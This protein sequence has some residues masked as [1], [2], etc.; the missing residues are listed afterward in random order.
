LKHLLLLGGGHSH[1][2]VIRRFGDRPRLEAAMTLVSPDRH[3]PYSGMLPGY[4]A[5]HYGYHDCHIDLE[6]LC[7]AAG[8]VFRRAVASQIHPEARRVVCSDGTVVS[9]D[10]V[11][12]DVGSTPDVRALH[13]ALEHGIRVKPV[14]E[15]LTAWEG[16][17][18][19]FRNGRSLS[20]AFVGGGAGAV[21]LAAAVHHRLA[22][23]AL[24][25]AARIVVL[26]DAASILP[27]HPVR[28]QRIFERVLRERG[29]E[30]RGGAK[31]VR[32][33]PGRLHCADGASFNADHAII[34]TGAGAPAWMTGSGLRTDAR[35]FIAINSHLQSLSHPNVFAAGD[36][37]TMIGNVRPKM[38]VYAVRQ[39]P[40]LHANLHR[41]LIGQ[42]LRRYAPQRTAL[43]LISTGDKHAV[44][45]WN[46]IAFEG[47][48]VWRWKDRIDRRF[49]ATYRRSPA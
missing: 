17:R 3:T 40:I 1:V 31:V 13:G 20:L 44:A 19:A 36:V 15:F 22:A 4:I 41:A 5:G 43:A 32:I 10:V 18:A 45:S 7:A 28:V 6:P 42:P 9:Y 46:G 30:V 11:S 21:E 37:G 2:E 48:W 23:E 27:T 24:V 25:R 38:G 14:A 8:I 49:M 29:I 47:E 35:G 33:S 26:T 39:G 16:I 34:A 12:I